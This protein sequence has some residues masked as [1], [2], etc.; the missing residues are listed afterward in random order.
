MNLFSRSSLSIMKK[1][2]V[3]PEAQSCLDT[4]ELQQKQI[5]ALTGLPE[6]DVYR[7]IGPG[8]WETIKWEDIKPNDIINVYHHN[9]GKSSLFTAAAMKNGIDIHFIWWN[10]PVVDIKKYVDSDRWFV[11]KY[12]NPYHCKHTVNAI[13]G[14]HAEV[15]K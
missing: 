11:G 1:L 9:S 12:T 8:K 15:I 7:L 14:I 2:Y 10:S 5:E 3:S 13:N 6:P 4:Y